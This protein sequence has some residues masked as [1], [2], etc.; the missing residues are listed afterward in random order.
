MPHSETWLRGEPWN[1]SS[2]RR[3]LR[4]LASRMSRIRVF[5]L[6]NKSPC[7]TV[8]WLEA[9]PCTGI[10]LRPNRSRRLLRLSAQL[11]RP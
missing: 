2:R 3:Y 1:G 9:D 7:K 10:R 6:A 5:C 11:R 8:T 4:A